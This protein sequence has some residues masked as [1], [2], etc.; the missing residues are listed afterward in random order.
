MNVFRPKLVAAGLPTNLRNA[1]LESFFRLYFCSLLD[2]DL[3]GLNKTYIGQARTLCCK[4]DFHIFTAIIHHL[5]GLTWHEEVVLCQVTVG[6]PARLSFKR[7]QRLMWT[8][9]VRNL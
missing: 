1:Q 9:A 3:K 6:S 7:R 4:Y 5:G 2:Q 8:R